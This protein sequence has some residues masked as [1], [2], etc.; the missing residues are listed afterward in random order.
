VRRLA[1]EGELG[2]PGDHVEHALLQGERRVQQL[3]HAQ[4]L[5]HADQLA[6]QLADVFGEG[7]VG[8]QQAVVGVQAGVAGVVVTGTQVRVT[9]DLTGSRRRISIILA[10]VLKPT[11][12]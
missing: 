4:G 7:V 3:L 8:G 10:W 6:E 11:T 12:P 2:F 9:H 5:A 1:V